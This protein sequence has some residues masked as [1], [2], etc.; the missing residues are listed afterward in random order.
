MR[1]TKGVKNES[2]AIKIEKKANC[3]SFSV[4]LLYYFVL[5]K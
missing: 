2:K 1:L 4:F 3:G 5:P